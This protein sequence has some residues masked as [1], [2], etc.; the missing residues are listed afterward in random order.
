MLRHRVTQEAVIYMRY[1]LVNHAVEERRNLMSTLQQ[2]EARLNNLEKA[3]LQSQKN[4]VPQTAKVDDT[5]N[6]VEQITPYTETKTAYYNEKEK[7]FYNVPS[8]NVTVYFSNYEGNYSVSRVSDR[9]T[10][11]FDT[12]TEQTDITISII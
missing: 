12:L 4:L 5:A 6:K 8:G 11:S 7:T 3:F 1:T 10:V 9:L 2:L